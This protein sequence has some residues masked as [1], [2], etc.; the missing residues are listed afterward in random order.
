MVSIPAESK[1]SLEASADMLGR[2]LRL[3]ANVTGDEARAVRLKI[4]KGELELFGQSVGRG[5][6]HAHMEIDYAGGPALIAFNPDYVLDGLKN[7]EREVVRLEFN[8]KSSPGKFTL[9]ESY[10][11][12]VMPITVDD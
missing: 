5:E 2:K 1:N 6:A 11:Y 7:A 9:G 12:I 3:V 10:I 8:D 4:D